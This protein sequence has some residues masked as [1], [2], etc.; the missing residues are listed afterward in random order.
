MHIIKLQT[1][2]GEIIETDIQ[3]AKCS[4]IIK[5][6]LEDCGMEDDENV[7]LSMVN[8][9]I[10]KK[11]LEWAEYHK[12]DA[13]PPKDD[14]SKEKRTDYI[15]PWDA[16]FIDV[17]E[18]TVFQLIAAANALDINGLFELSCKRAAILISGKTREE[19]R[20]MS[21]LINH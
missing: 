10:L 21:S 9:T 6:M 3:I 8:S 14:E 18:D 20:N 1:S 12:A 19:I 7:I 17:D 2:D 16:N 11:T 5:T 15:N 4:G 13:Q